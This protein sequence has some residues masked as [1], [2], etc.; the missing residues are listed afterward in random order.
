MKLIF[1]LPRVVIKGTSAIRYDEELIFVEN[2]M[3]FI[4]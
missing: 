4:G 2:E 1:V 3:C